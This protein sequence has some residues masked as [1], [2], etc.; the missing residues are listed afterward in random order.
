[1]FFNKKVTNNSMKDC[2]ILIQ[3]RI[4]SECLNLWIKNYKKH[5]VVLSVWE[6]EDLSQFKIPKHWV[7]VVNQYP[8]V[9]FRR[10]ANLDYQIITTLKGLSKIKTY[11]VIKVRA[12]EY[13]SNLEIVYD[14]LKQNPNKIVSGSMYFRN[15]NLYKFHCSDKLL[16][17]T[18]N[19]IFSMF[20]S[21]LH[22]LEIKLWDTTIPE[23]QLGLGFVMAMEKDFEVTH[24]KLE[25]EISAYKFSPQGSSKRI[26]QTMDFI[27]K[28][29]MDIAT[30]DFRIYSKQEPDWVGVKGKFKRLKVM[31]DDCIKELNFE[32]VKPIDDKPYMKKWFDIIDINEL[33][34]YIA[35]RNHHDLGR[36]WYRDNFD[37][38]EENCLTD[39]NQ[40]C[41]T[42]DSELSKN[43]L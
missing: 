17:G 14:R 43:N 15:W 18:W 7:V 41:T 22:N 37:H 16:A 10:E 20:E 1:M 23:S 30:T 34:P 6:D 32:D 19:N 36:I 21:T 27:V 40:I 28:A 39:I 12:D 3:G 11:Y 35:T 8:L 38:Y 13:W 9:R 4:N 5:N 29:C 33:K 25:Q 31:V 26:A 2:T 42:K 24:G